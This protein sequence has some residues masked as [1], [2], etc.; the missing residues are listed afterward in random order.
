MEQEKLKWI[1][2][3]EGIYVITS[4]GNVFSVV[5]HDKLGRLTGG[6]IKVGHN[7]CGYK[8]VALY[9]DGE[10]K[11]EYIHR[12]VAKAFIDNIDNKPCI[13]HIDNDKYNNDVCNLRWCS[14]KENMNNDITRKRML[15]DTS[16][17]I[18]Q[19]GKNNPF[20]REVGKY[21]WNDELLESYESISLAAKANGI[22]S[23]SISK[24]CKGKQLSSGGFIWRYMSEAKRVMPRANRVV[25]HKQAVVQ[26]DINGNFIREFESIAD[27][28]RFCNCDSSNISRAARGVT[29]S[30]NNCLWKYKD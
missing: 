25:F 3:Y 11:Q 14:H 28:A 22:S 17:Y 6:N 2:G 20:S 15:E 27:A 5:R 8:F 12:L 13:D 23:K 26:M 4:K 1:N 9:K 24:V 19:E 30:S 21:D 7:K 18:S 10:C 29:K 16:K